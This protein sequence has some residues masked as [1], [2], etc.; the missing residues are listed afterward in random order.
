MGSSG[1]IIHYSTFQL[2][3]LTSLSDQP[4]PFFLLLELEVLDELED[5]VE[6]ALGLVGFVGFVVLDSEDFL[7]LVE[8][9]P[10]TEGS[11][12]SISGTV[13]LVLESLALSFWTL[14]L[15]GFVSATGGLVCVESP[16]G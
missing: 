3:S 6:V 7:L 2:L 14:P 16:A 5:E 10:G 9:L 1:S 15:S 13:G 8:D 11:L 4:V 12:G